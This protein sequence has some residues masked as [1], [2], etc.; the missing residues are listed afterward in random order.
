MTLSALLYG[1][2]VGLSLG[3]T[4][5]GGSIFAVP[6][7]V[8]G[9]GLEFSKATALSL[10]IVAATALFGAVLHRG[11]GH[12]LWSHGIALGAGGLVG[13]PVG[14]LVAGSLSERTSLVLF[15]CLM[16]FIGVRMLLPDKSRRGKEQG[17]TQS[18]A[19]NASPS[20][21]LKGAVAL[22]VAG[23][24]TGVLSG[25]FGVGGGFL[26]TPALLVV[27][28]TEIHQAMATS[29]V[30]IVIIAS[31]G[32]FSAATRLSGISPAVPSL[33]LIGSLVGMVC[34]ILL[35][36]RFSPRTLQMVFGTSVIATAIF[37]VVRSLWT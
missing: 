26:L 19:S 14:A 1:S 25:L 12:V 31:F 37:V 18:G 21:R 17:V 36:R 6:L 22:G 13:L 23:V 20:L 35:K 32:F 34:G 8:Y 9:L 29:L 27:S 16:V 30:S 7:L 3:L 2:I 28:R 5:G 10:G 15:S 11:Q 24:V 4:G 33:F